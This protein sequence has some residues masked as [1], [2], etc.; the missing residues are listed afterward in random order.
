[1]VIPKPEYGYRQGHAQS[2]R[3]D[4]VDQQPVGQIGKVRRIKNR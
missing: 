2:F 3:F 4:F 1:M